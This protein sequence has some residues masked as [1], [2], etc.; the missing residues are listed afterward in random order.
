ARSA[1]ISMSSERSPLSLSSSPGKA[2]LPGAVLVK[3][4]Y[5]RPRVLGCEHA[6]EMQSLDGQ[7]RVQVDLQA[8]VDGPLGGPQRQRWPVRVLPGHLQR[9]G[10]DL[11][12][13]DHPVDQADVQRF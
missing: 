7:P 4:A 8:L 6:R 1:A 11:S 5:A 3:A 9:G 10:M 13:R 12:I 2:G